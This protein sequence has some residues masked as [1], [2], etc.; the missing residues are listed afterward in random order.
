VNVQFKKGVLGLCV[1]AL[2]IK[3]DRYGYEL[4]STISEKFEIAEGTIYPLLRKLT[5]EGYFSTYLAESRE[6][7]PRKYYRITE[8]GRRYVNSLLIEWR[9]FEQSVNRIIDEGTSS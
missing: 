2:A 8:Q 6:G 9:D 1:L 5:Q 7:P 3:E 4:V